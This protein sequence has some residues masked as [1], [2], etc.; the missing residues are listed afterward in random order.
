MTT[1]AL[2]ALGFTTTAELAALLPAAVR[3]RIERELLEE[4]PSAS[5]LRVLAT[6]DDPGW[7]QYVRGARI[8]W[9]GMFDWVRDGRAASHHER[10]RVEVAGSLAGYPGARANLMYA[11]RV[12]D[13]GN[14]AAV[15][16]ALR[17]M[18]EGLSS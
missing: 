17:I 1:S 3:D 7:H 11:M 15:M 5:A 12:L 14:H 18:R 8:D 2:P 9:P 6:V 13:S 10:I 4:P 16:D